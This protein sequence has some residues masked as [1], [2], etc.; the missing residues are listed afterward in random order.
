MKIV[1]APQ[2]FKGCLSAHEVTGAITRGLKNVLPG[3][4]IAALPMADGG[5]GTVDALVSA[6]NG[7][8]MLAEVTGPLGGRV[9]AEWG[10]LGKG[11]T[12]VLEMA[13][14]SG[15]T[16][17]PPDKLDPLVTTTYGTGELINAALDAGCSEIIIGI[18]GSATNDGG[19]GMAQSLGARLTDRQGIEI[20]P[21][22]AELE[23]L[24]HIDISGL[25]K[26]LAGCT[27][28][29]ACDVSNPLC[30]E[31]GA[32]H[33]YGP[34]KG[35]T[36]EMCRQL[37][38]A[39]ANYADVIEKDIGI[40]IREMPGGGAAGGLGAG[41]AAFLGAGIVPG[42]DI[43]SQIVGLSG[44][45]KDA[46]LV[47]TGEGRLDA[48][49]MYGKTVAGV[50]ARAKAAGVPVIA[51]AGELQGD[52]AELYQCGI[53]AALSIAPGPVTAEESRARAAQ[54]IS[55]T[56]EQAIRLIMINP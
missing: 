37:D 53:D 27:G 43:V 39:L 32:S 18:G 28:T 22:G 13:A 45:L 3:A 17:I 6:T 35:A 9:T 23:R 49:T 51:I 38:S 46:A 56:A 50:S 33:V 8:F 16:L 48:Q 34:Q 10:I 20:G 7:K 24:Y 21:G 52:L 30:G 15:L 26:R 25:D 31:D 29:I 1:V 47:F 42:I 40:D 54:L 4:D 44:H 14:A 41:L 2:S 36:A 5:E 19:S 12:A 55:D 11:S